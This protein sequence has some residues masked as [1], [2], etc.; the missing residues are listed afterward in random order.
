[1]S[2][3]R[4]RRPAHKKNAWLD[5]LLFPWFDVGPSLP[6]DKGNPWWRKRTPPSK[7]V[8]PTVSPTEPEQP[9]I[10]APSEP[11]E[12]R[13]VPLPDEPRSPIPPF[14]RRKR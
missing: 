6:G 10:I 7:P 5:L 4:Q 8:L 14:W 1:M 9:T 12:P 13:A 2:R 11:D 3:N